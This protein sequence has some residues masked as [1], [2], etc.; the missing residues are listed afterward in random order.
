MAG[1]DLTIN[2][3]VNVN[4]N[5]AHEDDEL[6]LEAGTVDDEIEGIVSVHWRVED[7]RDDGEPRRV[8]AC[9]KVSE[10]VRE[11]F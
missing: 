2:A 11:R 1:R 10:Q 5:E 9:R 7:S 3:V 8:R 4:G 6:V